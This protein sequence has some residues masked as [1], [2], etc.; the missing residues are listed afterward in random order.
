M[1]EEMLRKECDDERSEDRNSDRH[2]SILYTEYG[3]FD[4][5]LRLSKD[6]QISSRA[7]CVADRRI[8][9]LICQAQ[10]T[11][12]RKLLVIPSGRA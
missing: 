9:S 10:S 1:N 2:S 4:T 3:I 8:L 12:L 5:T 11:T 7:I 6:Y